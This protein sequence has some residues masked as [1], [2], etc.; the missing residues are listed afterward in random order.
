MNDESRK[1]FE[2]V[3]DYLQIYMAKQRVMSQNTI[4]SYKQAINQYLSFL[5]ENKSIKYEA[6]CFRDW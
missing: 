5:V 1:F 6:V 3:R 2:T 4:A